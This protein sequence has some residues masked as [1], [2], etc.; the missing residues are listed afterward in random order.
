LNYTPEK[1]AIVFRNS[2]AAA[3]G[4]ELHDLAAKAIRLKQKLYDDGSSVAQYVNDAIDLN[5][6][7]EQILRYSDNAFG[8]ADAIGFANKELHVCDLKTGTQVKGSKHQP[9]IYAAFFCLEYG[10]DPFDIVMKLRIYQFGE[11]VEWIPEPELIMWIMNKIVEFDRQLEELKEDEC[12][13]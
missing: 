13:A 5:L 12:R 6:L 10:I 3:K 4:T 9:E 1:L 2:D 11:I 8:T 7:P